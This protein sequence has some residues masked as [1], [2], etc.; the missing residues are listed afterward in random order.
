VAIIRLILPL[1]SS[2]L[3]VDVT[4]DLLPEPSKLLI[5]VVLDLLLEP[6]ESFFYRI[7]L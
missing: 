3:L 6:F 2:S 4:L 7:E 5:D 1:D